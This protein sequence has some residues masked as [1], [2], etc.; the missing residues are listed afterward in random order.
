MKKNRARMWVDPLF[1]TKFKQLACQEDTSLL[2]Y[3]KRIARDDLMTQ[4]KKKEFRDV[5]KI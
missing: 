2:E 3:T 1:K 4:P 5:F